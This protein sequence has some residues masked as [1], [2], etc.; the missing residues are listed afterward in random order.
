MGVTWKDWLKDAYEA[1]KE[2]KNHLSLTTDAINGDVRDDV[3]RGCKRGSVVRDEAKIFVGGISMGGNLAVLLAEED[4]VGGIISMGTP[5]KFRFQNAGKLALF[6]IGLTKTYR[7]KYYPPWVRKK[8]SNRKVYLYY[9]IENAKEV[10][11]LA[12]ETRKILARVTKP[13][14]IMQS[15]SDHMISKKSAQIIFENVK[16]KV[17]EIFWIKD[18]YHVFVG[19]KKVWEKIAQFILG[20]T[21]KNG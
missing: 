2:L 8:M 16:S 11:R 12:E 6:L 7:K 1:L 13:I 5:V 10:V 4:S 20:V 18:A 3:F 17:K 9:P 15:A 21:D 14:L 19:D